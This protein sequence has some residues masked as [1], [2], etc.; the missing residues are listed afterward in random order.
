MKSE[1]KTGNWAIWAAVILIVLTAEIRHYIDDRRFDIL[2]QFMKDQ[3]EVIESIARSMKS[4]LE[5]DKIRHNDTSDKKRN[6]S[7]TEDRRR[8]ISI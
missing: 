4:I 3:A 5:I 8:M 6:I 7:D 1:K 2:I